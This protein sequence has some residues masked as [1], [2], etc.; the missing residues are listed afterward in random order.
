[1]ADFDSTNEELAAFIVSV[2]VLGYCFGP[3][4]IAPLSEIYGRRPLYQVCNVFFV[5]F[6][7]ACAVAPNL[8]ALIVFRLLAG[9]AGSCPMAPWPRFHCRSG[10][11]EIE[12]K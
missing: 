1:M 7:I 8:E 12:E 2:Y 9:L 11:S 10:V 6:T 3:L 5:I 4:A